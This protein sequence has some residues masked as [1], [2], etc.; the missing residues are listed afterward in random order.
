MLDGAMRS[1]GLDARSRDMATVW[2]PAAITMAVAIRCFIV[3][4]VW[5]DRILRIIFLIAV[6][7][8]LSMV[9]ADQFGWLDLWSGW[10]VIWVAPAVLYWLVPLLLWHGVG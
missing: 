8:A 5:S 3:P 9:G 1:A 7:A 2:I 6:G 4:L 10:P